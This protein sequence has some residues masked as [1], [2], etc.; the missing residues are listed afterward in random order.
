MNDLFWLTLI[1]L[2]VA[3][4]LRSELFFYM[5][6]VIVGLQVAARFWMRRSAQHLRWTRHAPATLFLG[7]RADVELEV[8][9]TGLLP[10]PW[11][12]LHESIPPTLNSPAGVREVVSLGAGEERRLT[13]SIQAVRR[14]YYRLGPLTMRTGDVLGLGERT[15]ETN[16]VAGLTVYPTVLPL[17]ELHLPASLPFGVLP[18][19]S[20]LFVDPARPTG[21]R[22]YQPG[23]SMRSIDWKNSARASGGSSRGTTLLVRRYQPAIAL[24][25][26]VALAFGLEEYRS[27][28]A[29]DDMERALVAAASIA[30]HIITQRQAV[31][32]C[33]TGRDPLNGTSDVTL[34][35]GSGRTHL[36]EILGTLGRLEATREGSMPALLQQ[37]GARL[38]W[39]STIVFVGGSTPD[40]VPTLLPLRQRG[41][42]LALVLADA[43][44]ATLGLARSHGIAA[45][46]IGR[47][48]RPTA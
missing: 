35:I 34:P 30:A 21:V 22:P 24:E 12:S 45:Y 3:A 48:G 6:Y 33:T 2:I 13:Y 15:L 9:N 10:L 5:L 26:V 43:T 8:R 28:F 7:E 18:A 27:R 19:A 39:G 1:L 25:T 40:L 11:I 36:I 32:F 16:E 17:A 23:D 41:L 42:N 46:D 31:G 44:P 4:L 14:G 20:S 37:V 38:G 47:D 29:Y